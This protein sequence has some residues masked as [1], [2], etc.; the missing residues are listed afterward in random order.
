MSDELGKGIEGL[1]S[2]PGPSDANAA[3]RGPA[4]SLR[5]EAEPGSEARAR[6]AD[7]RGHTTGHDIQTQKPQDSPNRIK[8]LCGFLSADFHNFIIRL[9]TS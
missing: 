6:P 5:T 7:R 4:G 3:S 8:F 1:E 9:K 2:G